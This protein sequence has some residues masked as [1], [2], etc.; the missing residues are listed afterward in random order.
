MNKREIDGALFKNMLASGLS[1]LKEHVETVDELN[2]FP[3][4]D[5]DT[6]SNM[7]ST[8]CGGLKMISENDGDTLGE[9]SKAVG[10]GVLLGAR[11]NSGVILSQM[12]YGITEEFAQ[13][14]RAD[15]RTV[16]LAFAR[17]VNKA[18][19]S[20]SQPVEGTMLTVLREATEY[21]NSNITGESTLISY[22]TDFLEE[23]RKSLDRTP[24]L[25]PVLKEAGVVDSGGAGV[26]CIVKGMLN[27]LNGQTVDAAELAVTSVVKDIDFSLFN[28]NSVML[29]GYCTEFLLQLTHA[30]C[31]VENFSL[32]DMKQKLS[33]FGDSLVAVKSGTVVKIH[34]HTLNPGDVLKYAQTFGEFLT[35]KIEN[36]TLQHSE[37]QEKTRNVF[38]KNLTR[39][40]FATIA[41]ADGEGIINVFKELG[42]D[43]VIDG[44][45]GNNPSVEV[46]LNAFDSVN[47]DVIF[48]LPD[49]SNIMMAAKEAAALYKKSDVRVIN[50]VS[51]GDGYSALSALDYSSENADEISEV[52]QS[53]IDDSLCACVSRSVRDANVGGFKV[54]SGSY[55]GFI[56]KD[57][58]VSESK[59]AETAKRLVEKIYNDEKCFLIAFYGAYVTDEEK[60]NFEGFVN[61][62][63]PELEFYGIDGGQDIYDFMFVLQ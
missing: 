55:I 19:T 2:V 18:Y 46:F 29:Y 53:D 23:G 36:M 20:V 1:V 35:V 27:A 63:Y 16:G 15:I 3:I 30:K 51:M 41:V 31:N 44:G 10:K 22:F 61:K 4:P 8:L 48:V 13:H 21:A 50:A 57:I 5:G 33:S 52:M 25:L 14:E 9:V 62:T 49:N 42:A 28:E 17:G 58:F 12:L 6:G 39:K 11:G 32:D 26:L 45:Q 38:K 59:K 24:D 43:I 54:K 56:G 40:K 37:T 60:R 7:C 34:V 47:S